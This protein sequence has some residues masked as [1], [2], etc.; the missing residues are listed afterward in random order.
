MTWSAVVSAD[1]VAVEECIGGSAGPH[2]TLHNT[3]L[4][5]MLHH[6]LHS[7]LI[8]KITPLKNYLVC[9]K[10]QGIKWEPFVLWNA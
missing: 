10:T 6:G 2:I 9:D 3:K 4:L 8:C 7:Y 1:A 5:V